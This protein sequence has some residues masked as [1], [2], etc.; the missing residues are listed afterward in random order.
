MFITV[1]ISRAINRGKI[2]KRMSR[3]GFSWH[4]V[5]RISLRKYMCLQ[6]Y[7]NED[8]LAS[9][10]NGRHNILNY[11]TCKQTGSNAETTQCKLLSRR[12]RND[13]NTCNNSLLIENSP[14]VQLDSRTSKLHLQLGKTTWVPLQLQRLCY[15]W[16]VLVEN[17]HR[18]KVHRS[19][20]R[21]LRS[22]WT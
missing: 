12:I 7:A 18:I 14:W 10:M 17:D 5:E 22:K 15:I 9:V 6:I 8:I 4:P 11:L 13:W 3:L 1:L 21:K 16:I 19:A 20:S 2:M